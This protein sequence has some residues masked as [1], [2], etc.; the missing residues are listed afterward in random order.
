M[1]LDTIPDVGAVFCFSTPPTATTFLDIFVIEFGLFCLLPTDYLDL[2]R[3]HRL[4]L[5]CKIVASRCRCVFCPYERMAMSQSPSPGCHCH[6]NL[7]SVC[8][9]PPYASLPRKFR[10]CRAEGN[11]V[12][13]HPTNSQPT[14]EADAG[15]SKQACKQACKQAVHQRSST[16]KFFSNQLRGCPSTPASQPA[17]MKQKRRQLR[18]IVIFRRANGGSSFDV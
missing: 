7:G 17:C 10:R 15:K 1:A 3:P 11:A 8:P 6:A 16:R 2:L 13:L 5:L 4:S 12:A 9:C 14:N 18:L